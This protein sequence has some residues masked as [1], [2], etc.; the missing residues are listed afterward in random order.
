VSQADLDLKTVPFE[1]GRF[2]ST[3]G[4]YERHRLAYPDRL[5]ARLVTLLGLRPGDSVLDLGTGTGM[6][7]V[8]FA[9]LGMTVT[10]MDPEPGMLAACKDAA[11]MAGV[12]L[13]LR[14]ASSYDLTPDMG[15]FKLVTIGRSF[16]WMDRLA[17]LKM[18]G[19]IVTGDGGVALFHD[20][21]PPVAENNWF[22]VLRDVQDKFGRSEEPHV[23]ERRGGHSRYEPFLYQSQF[24][25]L[26]GLSVTIRQKLATEDLVGRAFSMST[27]SR[28]KLGDR[29]DA[30][31]AALSTA[32]QD[33][34]PDGT[35][36]E[37]AEL[38][39]LLARRPQQDAQRGDYA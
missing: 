7:A 37:V 29:A 35:F 25:Q 38:V 23:R 22:K 14:Q 34:S 33:L 10:A 18:L 2:A 39:A 6:L 15:P 32:L 20:A 16:H 28:E 9:R 19:E 13:T 8:G 31:A 12:N 24:T 4:Y 5:L 30:F 3:V 26:D 11:Q 17:T 21:H 27:C 1:P 36:V